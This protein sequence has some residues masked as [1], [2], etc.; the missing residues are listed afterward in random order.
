MDHI[1]N[2][3]RILT[4]INFV[5]L[6]DLLGHMKDNANLFIVLDYVP[7][8]ELFTV[9]RE[10]GRFTEPEARFFAAQVILALEVGGWIVFLF[11]WIVE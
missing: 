3:K 1:L 4:A 10:R 2:E 8:G 5:F 7:G 6:V 11:N 9:L